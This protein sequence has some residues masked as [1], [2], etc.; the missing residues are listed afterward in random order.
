MRFPKML[1]VV[2]LLAFLAVPGLLQAQTSS[3]GLVA[4][5][6][7]DK[8]GSVVPNAIV[9]LTNATTNLKYTQSTKDNGQVLFPSVAPGS[10]QVTVRKE[11]FRT[12]SLAKLDVEVSKSSTVDAVLELGQMAEIVEVTATAG[13]ELQTTDATVGTAISGDNLQYLP[14]SNRSVSGLLVLQPLVMPLGTGVSTDTGGQVAGARSDQSTFLI[15]GGDATS[16]TEASGGYNSGFSGEIRPMIPVP[17]ESVQELRVGT[18]NPNATFGRSQG[19]QV[20]MITKHGTNSYHG[21]A[22][23]YHQN[24]DLNAN[25]WDLNRQKKKRPELKDNRYGFTAGGYI[26]KDK[27]FF[28]GHFEGRNFPQTAT[29]TRVVPTPTFRQGIIRLRDCALGWD[30]ET[31]CMGG[32]VVSYNLNKANPQPLSAACTS[33]T[34]AGAC[35]PRNLGASPVTL[36][37]L[38]SLPQPTPGGIPGVGD[39]LNLNLAGYRDVVNTGLTDKFAVVRLDYTL[40]NKWSV[41]AS[42]RYQS[43]HQPGAQQIDIVG[44][45]GCKAPCSVRNNPLQPRYYVVGLNGQFSPNLL[46]ET[47]LSWFRHWWEWATE[48]PRPQVPGTAAAISLAGEGTGASGSIKIADPIN[49]NT[50]SAR[51]RVWNGHD[52]F[53][54]EN[55]TWLKG[56]HNFQFGGSYRLQNIFHQRTDKVTGGLSTGPI[57][58]FDIGNFSP[59]ASV[60]GISNTFRPPTCSAAVTANCIRS[61]DRTRW[62]KWYGALMGIPD[63]TTQLLTRD[64]DLKPQPLGQPLQAQVQIHSVEGFFQDIWRV[65]P[66]LNLTL[67]I[68][69]QVQRPPTEQKGRQIVPVIASTNT[70]IDMDSYFRKREAAAAQGDIFNPD[71]AFSP[72]RHVPGNK[73][74]VNHI[75]WKGVGPRLAFAWNPS[76]NRW[77]LGGRKTVLRGGWG[78]NYTR[79]NGVGLVMTPVLGVGLG[80]ILACNGPRSDGT[81]GGNSNPTN[82]FRVGPDGPGSAI[83]PS[84]QP[85]G[86]AQIPFPVSAPYGETRAFMIDPGFTLGYSHSF[87][88]TLQRELPWNFLIEVGYVGRLGRNLTQN[89]DLNAVPFMFKDKLSGQTLGEAFTSLEVALQQ[90]KPITTQPW[91][92]NMARTACVAASNSRFGCGAFKTV[93][94]YLVDQFPDEIATGD[95]AAIMLSRSGGIDILRLGAGQQPLDNIQVQ[96]NNLTSHNGVSNY[97]AGF[98]SLNKRMS[99]GLTFGLN[100]TLGHSLDTYGL[101]QENTQ[102]SFSSPFRRDLDYQPSIFDRRHVFNAHSTYLLPFGKGRRWAANNAILDKIVGG[103][104]VAGIWSKASG[105]PQCVSDGNAP[106]NGFNYGAPNPQNACLLPVSGFRRPDSSVHTIT[107]KTAVANLTGDLNMFADPL[108]VATQWRYPLIGQDGRYGGDAI[109]GLSRWTVDLSV[110]KLTTI[111]ERVKLGF[112]ADFLNVFNH[113]LFNQFPNLDISDVSTFGVLGSQSNQPRYIQ[114]GFRIEF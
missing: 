31:G 20:A 103:W 84:K 109:R 16:D 55:L 49:I 45:S 48:A 37:D 53:I 102:F 107:D 47:R 114:F 2:V 66:S 76:S 29:F 8:T 30:A 71:I 57:F 17:V 52:T 38:R 39:P 64:G 96:I 113:P 82:A 77:G 24:D 93:T 42:G 50:Q 62:N 15:D 7:S 85:V 19:G 68:T 36:A 60:N 70:P 74:V 99:N 4:G 100:Y 72:V 54:S 46:T 32:D 101:N 94:A 18:T 35:D 104:H 43:F 11:G 3:S 106:N 51:S 12:Y 27:L 28:F 79:M 33:P 61:S 5:T 83:L 26:W 91:F 10:Y 90:G 67:G 89:V 9:E 73:Y 81:C 108:K 44:I 22:Y 58:Y 78:V 69:Y 88:L 63:K 41:F 105:L 59:V 87:D 97:H 40:N 23:W 86:P 25:T 56:K 80:Q 98:I 1:S 112:T 6:V 95:L 111:T 13:A 21:S 92:E 65:T 34:F 75:Y 110:G 14:T